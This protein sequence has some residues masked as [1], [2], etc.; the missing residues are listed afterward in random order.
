M[1]NGVVAKRGIARESTGEVVEHPSQAKGEYQKVSGTVN[2]NRVRCPDGGRDLASL[3]LCPGQA[4]NERG[5]SCW[6]EKVGE[7]GRLRSMGRNARAFKIGSIVAC[8]HN[9]VSNKL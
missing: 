5:G 4:G 3:H 2:S 1:M 8:M 9:F 6:A 7:G